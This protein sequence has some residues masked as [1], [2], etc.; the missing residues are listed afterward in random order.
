MHIG[1]S[2][3]MAGMND[4]EF[5]YGDFHEP[6]NP[7]LWMIKNMLSV[8]RWSVGLACRRDKILRGSAPTT[9]LMVKM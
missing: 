1:I 4:S 3:R 6:M 7:W 9:N 2:E 5:E 8:K